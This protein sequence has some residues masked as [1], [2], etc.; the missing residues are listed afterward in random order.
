MV[1]SPAAIAELT[2]A[3]GAAPPASPPAGLELLPGGARQAP[4]P[5]LRE[6][7][8]I[9]PAG[10]NVDGS[11]VWHLSDPVR[12]LFY[13]IGWL[14]FEILTRWEMGD[15]ARI[16]AAVAEDTTLQPID[17]DVLQFAAFLRHNQLVQ[18]T[19]PKPPVRF[20][21]W[22]L[23][24]Y[25]S[26]RIP[27]VRPAK[28]LQRALPWLQ[29]LFS[30]WF[31]GL[32]AAAASIGL[33][34]SARQWDAVMAN[35]HGAL[36]WDGIVGYLG[37]LIFSKLLHE[38]G[39]A[40]VATR[41]G[42]RV[43]H[44]GV[45]LLVLWPMAYTDTGES[46]KLERSRRRLA[47]ASAGILTELMLAAWSTF[48]W[49]FAPEGN[50]KNALF[51]LATTAWVLTLT[52]NASPFMRFDG[53]FILA[54]ALDFPGLHERAGHWGKR[55]MRKRLMGIE[56]PVAEVLPRHYQRFLTA[57][58]IAT[59]IYRLILFFGIALVVYHKFFKALGLFLFMVEISVFIVRPVRSEMRVWWARRA[60]IRR[61]HLAG[62]LLILV[63]GAAVLA[64]PW[65]TRI[66]A[67]GVLRAGVEQP[68]YSPYA[69]RLDKV[70]IRNGAAVG[71]EQVLLELDAPRQAEERDKASALAQAYARSARGAVGI[72]DSG[73]ARQMLA[74]QYAGRY[75][76]ERRA[77]E[78]ELLRLKLAA[79]H[80]GTVRDVDP[81]LQP[82]SW[83]S[84]TTRIAMLVGGDHWRVEALVRERDRQRLAKGEP[85]RVYV[86]GRYDAPLA[87]CIVDIDD[88][89]A[90][91]LP[92]LLL[93]Q[94]NGGPIP[95]NP[96]VPKDQLKPA[97]TWYRVI[98]EGRSDRPV[99]Q[100]EAVSVHFQGERS[101]IG[102]KWLDSALSVLI[103]QSGT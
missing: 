4:W 72:D 1:A 102:G 36:S 10:V 22:L 91:R 14:E 103:Q 17:E 56:D 96:T 47:I 58:A 49:V 6:E 55:F 33:V 28:V 30:G 82:G 73:A 62:W 23:H 12:N 66:V 83:V 81:T 7:L 13:R 89:A 67:P 15:P 99:E 24:N 51:F 46:W 44:M 87:G 41:N 60:E 100:V 61:G 38:C 90:T 77:R 75:E 35:L 50:F 79:L 59:W 63:G 95:L 45:A 20:A 25:L 57:F 3:A 26:I 76:A 11:P 27:L 48:F 64:V 21:H 85:A 98:V 8:Q 40:L 37:A 78:A 70:D 31:F 93:A 69:A 29:W 54:D 16:A 97:D 32:T 94:P 2:A 42:V 19:R 71:D 80:G 92:H 18:E 5:R 43:G 84:A 34:L 9:H 39:H 65:S 68:V 86:R 52:V 53:Y 74:D 101:S 88:S